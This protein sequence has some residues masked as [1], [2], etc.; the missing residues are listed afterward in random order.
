MH[1]KCKT[2]ETQLNALITCSNYKLIINAN[3][4]CNYVQYRHIYILKKTPQISINF[5]ILR[6]SIIHTQA[7]IAK[8]G[9]IQEHLKRRR[10][11]KRAAVRDVPI[12]PGL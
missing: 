10:R 6:Q 9:E 8:D 3:S 5:P 11:K 1:E 7:N 2:A 12:T 4:K